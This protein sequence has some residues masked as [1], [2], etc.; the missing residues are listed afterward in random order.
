[1]N[2]EKNAALDVAE[3]RSRDK[4]P[5]LPFTYG[6]GYGSVQSLVCDCQSSLGS[7]QAI[8]TVWSHCNMASV[9]KAYAE[10]F[11]FVTRAA[12]TGL[13]HALNCYINSHKYAGTPIPGIACQSPP[14]T[15]APDKACS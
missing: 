12:D 13:P 3:G 6:G 14:W 8:A 9:G 11:S 7:S 5:G 4:D 2:E 10:P 1:M 15:P